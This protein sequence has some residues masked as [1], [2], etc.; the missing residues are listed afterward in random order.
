[1]LL[2]SDGK[3]YGVSRGA[4]WGYVWRINTDGSGFQRIHQ[5]NGT[6]GGDPAGGL[7]QAPDGFL[8]GITKG[9]G[10]G[11]NGTIYRIDLG[12]PAPA[13]NRPPVAILD[14]ANSSGSAVNINVLANDFDADGDTLTVSIESQP[15]FGTAV[16]QLDGTI[17]LLAHAWAV[18]MPD[19]TSSATGS[20]I[21][22]ASPV[23]P[24]S[25]S[26][27]IRSR[28]SGSLAFTMES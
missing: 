19:T 9:G 3:I 18:D 23:Q 10:N 28:R 21:P 5:F 14:Q 15:A 1:M 27:M 26:A 16:V 8:Y 13:V 12:L 17:T 11:S 6:N 2:A 7:V 4:G 22:R 25:S 24:W 20:P